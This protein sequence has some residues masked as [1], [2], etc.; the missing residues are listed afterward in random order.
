MNKDYINVLQN[1]VKTTLNAPSIM[2]QKQYDNLFIRDE[3]IYVKNN[4]AD[5]NKIMRFIVPKHNRTSAMKMML[6]TQRTSKRGQNY[7]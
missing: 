7:E 2:L 5:N 1:D 6:F 4:D 3:N